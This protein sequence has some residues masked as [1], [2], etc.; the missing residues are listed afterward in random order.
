MSE[1]LGLEQSREHD[2]E[3]TL[4]QINHNDIKI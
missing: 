1:E 3:L 4:R 2:Q